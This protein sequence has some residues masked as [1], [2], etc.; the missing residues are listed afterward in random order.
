M[1]SVTG[2]VTVTAASYTVLFNGGENVEGV[3]PTQNAVVS[4]TVIT[5]PENTFTKDG[6]VFVGWSDEKN[7]YNAGSE[8][9]VTGNVT[10]T[11]VWKELVSYTVSFNGG[12]NGTG[13]AP[14]AQTVLEGTTI[15][16][17]ANTFT[18]SNGL[19]F[20]GWSDGKNTYNAGSEYTVI[21]DVTFVAAWGTNNA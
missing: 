10:F 14:T 3:A 5:L 20:L 4:Q 12:D 18:N 17:P 2:S 7:T 13:D 1:S 16:L 6:F 9:T 11:A 19:A 21:H 15:T 8:Y